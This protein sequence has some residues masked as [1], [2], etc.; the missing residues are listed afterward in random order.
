LK[1]GYA[2]KMPISPFGDQFSFYEYYIAIPLSIAYN[3][4]LSPHISLVPSVGYSFG[5]NTSYKLFHESE[6][7]PFSNGVRTG[8]GSGT[9]S[10]GTLELEADYKLN[11]RFTL[12]SAVEAQYLF[13]ENLRYPEGTD[14]LHYYFNGYTCTFNAGVKYYFIHKHIESPKSKETNKQ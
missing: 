7:L 5:F 6:E 12:C 10:F 2:G 11:S 8:M 13:P 9:N 3:I 4:S 14:P 1:T